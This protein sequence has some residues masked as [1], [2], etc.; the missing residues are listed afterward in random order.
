[1][2]IPE[3]EEVR[4]SSLFRNRQRRGFRNGPQEVRRKP[5]EMPVQAKA[6]DL[7]LRSSQARPAAMR[8]WDAIYP[9]PVLAQTAELAA[10]Q[11]THSGSRCV[12]E[13]VTGSKEWPAVRGRLSAMGAE[14]AGTAGNS[15]EPFDTPWAQARRGNIEF[16]RLLL[17]PLNS[18]GHSFRRWPSSPD[19]PHPISLLTGSGG[20]ASIHAST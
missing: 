4:C 10:T 11:L 9:I 15:R 5:S 8:T 20:R 12:E 1:M 2:T 18:V 17:S 16:S 3:S 14:A 19:E 7:Q 13:C 6:K